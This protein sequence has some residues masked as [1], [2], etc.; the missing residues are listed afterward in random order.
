MVHF[1]FFRCRHSHNLKYYVVNWDREWEYLVSAKHQ[2]TINQKYFMYSIISYK[3][4]ICTHLFMVYY[5][6]IKHF[7]YEHKNQ[8]FIYLL[9]FFFRIRRKNEGKKNLSV[10][11]TAQKVLKKKKRKKKKVSKRNACSKSYYCYYEYFYSIFIVYALHNTVC[12]V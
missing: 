7:L 4:K 5:I 1:I 6:Y 9:M 2:K 8:R 3:Y 12:I 11:S 10:L